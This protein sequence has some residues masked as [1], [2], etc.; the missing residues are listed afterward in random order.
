MGSHTERVR[1]PVTLYQ[2]LRS[3]AVLHRAWK[4]VRAS[5]LSSL[6]SETERNT[7]SFDDNSFNNL[8]R[9]AVKLRNR[10]FKFENEIGVA[11]PKGRG[12]SGRR[13]LVVAPIENRI[14]R[15]AIL[16]VLQGYDHPSPNTRNLWPGVSRVR[17]VLETPTSV[18]GIPSRGVPH[19]LSLIDRAVQAGNHWFIRSDIK[20]FF[21]RIPVAQVADFIRGAVE[22]ED[23][24]ALFTDALATNLKNRAELEERNHFTLFPSAEIG[25]AQG[26]ALSALAGNIVLQQFDR[27]MNGRGIVCVRY[28]DDF[29]LLGESPKKVTAAFASAQ[30]RLRQLGMTVYDLSDQNARRDGKVDEGNIHNGTDVLGY[31]VSAGSLQPS[32][33]ARKSLLAKL[34]KVVDLAKSAMEDAAAGKTASRLHLYHQSVAMIHKITWGWSQSFK[35]CNARHV[36]ENLDKQID[37][38]LSALQRAAQNLTRDG[39]PITRRRVAGVH[40]LQET[41]AFPLP[42]ISDCQSSITIPQLALAS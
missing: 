3:R 16:D 39:S 14:V 12:K 29:I 17:D 5:G 34:D 35:Y 13:P 30:E 1:V 25:V 37:T 41:Y 15:R 7:K 27:A 11:L 36:L 23:F 33:D 32:S 20:D 28:I 8:E 42:D 31:R 21:T 22:D 19:G 18:G 10:R 9:L 38:R 2:R 4:V 26:S 6:S 24:C 40:L